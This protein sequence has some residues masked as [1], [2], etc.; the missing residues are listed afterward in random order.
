[1][2]RYILKSNI[3][4]KLPAVIVDIIIDYCGLENCT[5]FLS[6]SNY[7]R[8]ARNVDWIAYSC[9]KEISM[10]ILCG[11]R[12]VMT[13]LF[14]GYSE[15]DKV[16][17]YRNIGF[18]EV[19]ADIIDWS[20]CLLCTDV[21]EEILEANMDRINKTDLCRYQDLSLDFIRKYKECL[22]WKELSRKPLPVRFIEEMAP[23][24]C[25][26]TLLDTEYVNNIPEQLICKNRKNIH[27][28]SVM[29]PKKVY[30]S[31]EFM[32]ENTYWLDAHAVSRYQN[33]SLEFIRDKHY[34]LVPEALMENPL[35]MKQGMKVIR[36][37]YGTYYVFDKRYAAEIH[38]GMYPSPANHLA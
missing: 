2:G 22:N 25:W 29:I 9:K 17:L 35:L 20:F 11:I 8:H 14:P 28:Y 37:P 23:Y 36:G 12:D 21:P 26:D 31:E 30:L 13:E 18:L 15:G 6:E 32:R 27:N 10:F 16:I 1:M 4:L 34:Y 33:L 3:A 24:I 38:S 19:Y 7:I 5:E